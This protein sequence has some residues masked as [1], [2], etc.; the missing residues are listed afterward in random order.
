[1]KKIK[2]LTISILFFSLLIYF[3]KE[4]AAHSGGSAYVIIND[5]YVKENPLLDYSP[6]SYPTAKFK[7]G[8]DIATPSGYLVGENL[9]FTV[10][11]EAAPFSETQ[12]DRQGQISYLWNFNDGSQP[13][14][15]VNVNH[16]FTKPG[17]YLIDLSLKTPKKGEGFTNIN[18][19]QLTI[20]PNKDYNL[21]QVA[22]K[23]NGKLVKGA[24]EE[25]VEVRPGQTVE[26]EA[27]TQDRRIVN[28]QWD[29]G[30]GTGATG[31]KVKHRFSSEDFF[32][33][34]PVLR[35]TD[36]NNIKTDT[37]V[38]LETPL[39]EPNIFIRIVDALKDFLSRR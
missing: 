3:P 11:E 13:S 14:E 4:A 38:V 18:T 24:G 2:L 39:E 16:V 12:E 21:P 30:D 27:V 28:Y 20:T 26:F 32:A 31:K 29:F 7:M 33:T 34:Y 25:T 1:M 35:V 5:E 17:T 15:G 6:T 23:I 8:Q 19:I 37:F 10:D 36:K 9:K 22:V